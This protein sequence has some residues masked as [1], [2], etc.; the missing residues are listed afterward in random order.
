MR[1]PDFLQKKIE[2]FFEK[3]STKGL[4]M[5]RESLSQTYRAHLSSES[6]FASEGTRLAYL[7]TRLPATFA[8]NRFVLAELKR[9][10]PDFYPKTILDLGAG[11]GTATL[12]A[13]D[14]FDASFVL[15][16]KSGEAISLGRELME[17]LA[18][19]REWVRKD[20]KT[21]DETGDLAILS[22]S[23][24]EIDRFEPILR[25]LWERVDT[26]A[27]IEP[28]TPAGYQ[29]ILEARTLF[30]QL[31]AHFIAPCPHQK[32]CP[33]KENDWCHFSTRLERSRLHR[34][35]KEGSLGFEDEKFSYLI[36]SKQ[37]GI[38][39]QNRV[40]RHPLKGS[41]HVHLSLC[42]TDGSHK[43]KIVSKKE[44]ELYRKAR[45]IK[46]GENYF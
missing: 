9:R 15:V 3:A 39:P 20:L 19:K 45:N 46:W 17:E 13:M 4:K 35:L 21:T 31:G 27:I 38:P 11:P 16:E 22:Y 42:T 8:A 6:I 12:A 34:A 25:S 29:V 28:G 32:N 36:V 1:L 26:I 30:C 41:G 44:K 33:L 18:L 2:S 10:M 43:I 5:A 7:A 40:L 14:L 23:I 37:R 24:G